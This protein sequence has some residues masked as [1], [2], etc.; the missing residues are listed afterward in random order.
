LLSGVARLR[1]VTVREL[2]RALAS[3]GILTETARR[4]GFELFSG[5]G[6]GDKLEKG[7]GDSEESPLPAWAAAVTLG[8]YDLILTFFCQRRGAVTNLMAVLGRLKHG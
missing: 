5:Q 3:L 4:C 6:F 7:V 1:E 2:M 8:Y